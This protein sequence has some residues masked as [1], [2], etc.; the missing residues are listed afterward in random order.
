[1]FPICVHFSINLLL[2]FAQKF[3][4][5]LIITSIKDNRVN[6]FTIDKHCEKICCFTS[7][8]RKKVL[9]ATCMKAIRS[10]SESIK[11]YTQIAEQRTL[12]LSINENQYCP[13]CFTEYCQSKRITDFHLSRL[14]HVINRIRLLRYSF[15]L[16]IVYVSVYVKQNILQ[17]IYI[18]I[19]CRWIT[20]KLLNPIPDN[21]PS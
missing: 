18:F 13:E 9:L 14:S 12:P 4:N 6:T 20:P 15:L 1:M 8:L 3:F 11:I 21:I 10:T 7:R 5:C 2:H 16:G 19:I 17:Y